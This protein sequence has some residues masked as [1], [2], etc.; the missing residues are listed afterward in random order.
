[1]YSSCTFCVQKHTVYILCLN[2][3]LNTICIH[4]A[5]AHSSMELLLIALRPAFANTYCRFCC[6]NC[7]CIWLLIIFIQRTLRSL[8]FVSVSVTLLLKKKRKKRKK[9]CKLIFCQQLNVNFPGKT[10]CLSYI[11]SFFSLNFTGKFQIQDSAA[12]IMQYVVLQVVESSQT[13]NLSS[14]LIPCLYGN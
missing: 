3:V 11:L 12:R 2:T 9:K 13:H 8:K 6:S 4:S 10:S 1:M 14:V 5:L 7:C